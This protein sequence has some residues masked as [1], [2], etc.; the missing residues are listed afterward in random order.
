MMAMTIKK[1]SIYGGKE[2]TSPSGLKLKS[3][4][5]KAVLE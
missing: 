2:T 4:W 5:A 3:S 1:E